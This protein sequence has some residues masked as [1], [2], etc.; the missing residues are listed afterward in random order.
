MRPTYILATPNDTNTFCHYRVRRRIRALRDRH[1]I[2]YDI[3]E[4]SGSSSRTHRHRGLRVGTERLS[5]HPHRVVVKHSE[6][7]LIMKIN[8]SSPLF[9]ITE[10]RYSVS[11]NTSHRS[12]TSFKVKTLTAFCVNFPFRTLERKYLLNKSSYTRTRFTFWERSALGL[13]ES[14]VIVILRVI[15]RVATRA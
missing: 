10:S 6:I 8:A 1:T 15:L 5:K 14:S 2:M 12:Y 13:A 3:E 7:W 9:Q 11:F 4:K